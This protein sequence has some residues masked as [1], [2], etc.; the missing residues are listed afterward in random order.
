MQ[1]FNFDSYEVDDHKFFLTT[2][3]LTGTRA[4]VA[5][6][7]EQNDVHYIS[8]ELEAASESYP[9][10]AT[11]P[12]NYGKVP[13]EMVYGVPVTDMSEIHMSI[14]QKDKESLEQSL[15]ALGDQVLGPD[16]QRSR[17][18]GRSSKKARKKMNYFDHE[19][20]LDEI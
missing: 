2:A 12:D 18:E 13:D 4:V 20:T 7:D 15:S 6:T 1:D 16:S 10:T 19:I 5:V 14:L 17:P 11:V 9:D 8:E 3:N